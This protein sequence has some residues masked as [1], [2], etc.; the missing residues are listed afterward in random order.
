MK[1]NGSIWRK[2]IES[3]EERLVSLKQQNDS[4]DEV[5]KM[6]GQSFFPWWIRRLWWIES[7]GPERRK[8]QLQI[9]KE[10]YRGSSVK[11]NYKLKRLKELLNMVDRAFRLN[12]LIIRVCWKK[13]KIEFCSGKWSLQQTRNCKLRW[14]ISDS[15]ISIERKRIQPPP[16]KE[17]SWETHNLKLINWRNLWWFY[18]P[19]VIRGR[20]IWNCNFYCFRFS[21]PTWNRIKTSQNA[22]EMFRQRAIV[23]NEEFVRYWCDCSKRNWRN[24]KGNCWIEGKLETWLCRCCWACGRWNGYEPEA[25]IEPETETNCIWCPVSKLRE[26]EEEDEEV[27][28]EVEHEESSDDSVYEEASDPFQSQLMNHQL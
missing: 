28:S 11:H 16:M 9:E 8:G 3:L 27:E 22:T 21:F 23:S 26:H 25:E 5:K 6:S 18:S 12:L 24:A 20:E 4:L 10:N 17:S 2:T 13:F 19:I 15:W 7:S 1:V 14:K